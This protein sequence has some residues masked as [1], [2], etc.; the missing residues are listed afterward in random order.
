MFGRKVTG[1]LCGAALSVLGGQ[2][3]LA[4]A[5]TQDWTGP[6]LGASVGGSQMSGDWQTTQAFDPALLPTSFFSDP[7]AKFDSIG[8]TVTAFAGY[9]WQVSRYWLVGVEGDAHFADNEETLDRIPGLG[10]PGGGSDGIAST[11][12][13]TSKFGGSLRLRGGYLVA[14][15]IL[16][17]GTAGLALQQVDIAAT[18][19]LDTEVCNPGTGTKRKVNDSL[20][21]GW[22]VGAGIEV[23]LEDGWSVRAEYRYADYGSESFR[24]LDP[25]SGESFGADATLDLSSQS[26]SVGISYKF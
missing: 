15:D 13:V 8:V 7:E 5:L 24:A 25:V 2:A 16:L 26:L 17:F 10:V 21:L 4:Q 12:N 9:D 23:L 20:W 1:L 22:T 3:A 19:P 14:P 18:C 6:Y 11:T